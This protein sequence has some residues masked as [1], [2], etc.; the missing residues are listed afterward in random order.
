MSILKSTREWSADVEN[1]R[2]LGARE[3]EIR[4]F[5]PP[6]LVSTLTESEFWRPGWSAPKWGVLGCMRGGLGPG[7][8]EERWSQREWDATPKLHNELLNSSRQQSISASTSTSCHHIVLELASDV[9][10]LLEAD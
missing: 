9:S 5:T 2:G 8:P 4:A 7:G 6:L 3:D 10:F 1:G